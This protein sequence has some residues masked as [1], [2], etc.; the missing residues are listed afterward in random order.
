MEVFQKGN[1]LD[2]LAKEETS[3]K[4]YKEDGVDILLVIS[5][6]SRPFDEAF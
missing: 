3:C 1:S 5:K 4:Y 2:Y 6:V